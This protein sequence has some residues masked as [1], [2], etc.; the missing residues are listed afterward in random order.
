ML[1]HFTKNV[2]FT[3]LVRTADRLRE[4][5]FRRFAHADE[6]LFHVDVADD[7]GNRI[8]FRMRKQDANWYITESTV[9]NWIQ[10]LEK[11]LSNLIVEEGS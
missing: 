1:L 4:F 3:R 10:V 6:Y 9:P 7:R 2:H 8:I 5:N 11:T